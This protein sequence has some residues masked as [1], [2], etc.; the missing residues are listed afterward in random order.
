MPSPRYADTRL[1]ETTLGAP[2]SGFTNTKSP[3]AVSSTRVDGIES[4]VPLSPIVPGRT[5]TYECTFL[6]DPSEVA[7]GHIQRAQTLANYLPY[8]DDVLVY[9]PPGLQVFYREQYD[10]PSA[11]ARI[12]PLHPTHD[13][14]WEGSDPP[15]DR[16][17]MHNSRWG[18]VTGGELSAPL[19]V[20]GPATLQLETVTIAAAEDTGDVHI[21]VYETRSEAVAAA[22]R[23]GI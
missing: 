1:A 14:T 2:P 20:D 6:P 7:G 13:G 4:S 23:S 18:V 11:L 17:S 16:E 12:A 8:A 3:W 15:P 10:G 21:P 19:G 5:V 22:E 9:D